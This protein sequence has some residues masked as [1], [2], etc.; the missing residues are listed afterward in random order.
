MT[1]QNR[2]AVRIP[3]DAFLPANAKLERPTTQPANGAPFANF[4][5][6]CVSRQLLS[7]FGKMRSSYSN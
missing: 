3:P 2:P 7:R 1:R 4:D 5:S 6:M